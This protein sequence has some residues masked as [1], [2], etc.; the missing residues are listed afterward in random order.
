MKKLLALPLALFVMGLGAESSSNRHHLFHYYALGQL[1]YIHKN[2]KREAEGCLYGFLRRAKKDTVFVFFAMVGNTDHRTATD[3]T[4][5]PSA[6]PYFKVPVSSGDTVGIVGRFHTHQRKDAVCGPSGERD[7]PSLEAQ[8]S[9]VLFGAVTCANG[10]TL[11][12]F[13]RDG[14]WGVYGLPPDSVLYAP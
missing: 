10:D 14:S 7:I 4:V 5:F 3:S 2:A 6:C 11:V 12:V 13:E 9:F 8:D 1:R